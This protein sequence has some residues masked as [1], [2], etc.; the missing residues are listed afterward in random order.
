MNI[1]RLIALIDLALTEADN[2]VMTDYDGDEKPMLGTKRALFLLKEELQ[3]SPLN[4]NQRVLR[5]M[6]DV[7]V[8]AV[9][10]YYLSPLEKAIKNVTEILYNEI[11]N[12]KNLE[13]LRMDFGKGNP[14]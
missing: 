12:Y 4:I 13:P 14:I 7:G 3:N 2:F 11:P 10:M 6:H 1:N 5:A 9:K 8:A